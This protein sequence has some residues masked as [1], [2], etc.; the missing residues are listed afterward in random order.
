METVNT[1]NRGFQ[2]TKKGKGENK[3]QE[4]D[5][6][7]PFAMFT[8]GAEAWFILDLV[9]KKVHKKYPECPMYPL[10][11]AIYTIPD[12]AHIIKRAMIDE[13]ERLFGQALKVG[14]K[15]LSDVQGAQAA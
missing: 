3:W 6:K 1:V 14:Q 8:Q 15:D 5:L 2:K 12:Y 10:H 4:G 11:D 13:S 9:C 7:C